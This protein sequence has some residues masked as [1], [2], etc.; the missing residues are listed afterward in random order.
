VTSPTCSGRTAVPALSLLAVA[1]AAVLAVRAPASDLNQPPINY[2]TATPENAVSRLQHDLAAGKLKLAHEDDRG[3]LK[4]ALAA[5]KVPESSQVLVFSKTSL[6]RGRITPKTPRAIYFN[7][8]VYVGFCLRGDVIEV[9]VAD[10]AL[11]TVFYTLDQEPAERPRFARQTETCLICHASSSN[12]GV[13]GHLVRSVRPDRTGE[14]ILG[15]GTYRTD[16]TSPMDERWGGWYV[17]GRHGAMEHLGNRVYRG[18]RDLDD[19]EPMGQAQN[20]TDLRSYFSTGPYLSPHSDIVALMVLGHQVTVHNRIARATLETRS[21]VHYQVELNKALKEPAGTKYD[22]V[23]HRIASVGDD[24]VKGLLFSE[25]ARLTDKVEGT[26]AFA[27]EFA[28][29]GPFDQKGRSL[30]EF[31]LATRL[32][33]YPCSYLIYTES[34]DKLPAEVKEYALR[35]LYDVLTGKVTDK[36]FAH[37]TAADRTAILDI[38][39]DTKPNLP[40]YW[41]E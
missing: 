31:D 30:R 10:P 16:D 40:G 8:D 28:A 35:R 11:G 3:Y 22:S 29:R 15:S 39:R 2:E 25:E 38:L 32:F 26:T 41:R 7:D 18:R 6:Q 4:S 13:P 24:L 5:L 9:S 36:A 20:V 27:K 21:A 23:T 14:P 17:T 19:P 33:K 1:V 12:R 34:F 37:L